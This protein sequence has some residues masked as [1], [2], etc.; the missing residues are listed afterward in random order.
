VEEHNVDVLVIGSGAAG[1]RAS[2]AAREAGAKVLLLSRATAG[3]ATSTLL[4]H[5]AFAAS[6]FGQSIEKHIKKTLET[7]HG[8]NDRQLVKILAEEAPARVWELR[9]KGIKFR[10]TPQGVVAEGTFPVLGRQVIQTLIDWARSTGVRT[11]S[12]IT[13]VALTRNGERVTGCVAVTRDGKPVG[14]RAKAVVLCTGGASA[15]FKFHDN[16][17]F[18]IGDGYALAARSGAAIED[19]EFIQ[20]YP[21]LIIIPR[22]PRI[23]VPPAVVEKGKIVNGAGEDI[24]AKYRLATVRPVA[25]RARDTL[26]IAIYQEMMEGRSVYL[27][28][29][30]AESSDA[31]L[32]LSDREGLRFLENRYQSR[33][34]LIP[35]MPCAHFTIG[36]VVINEDCKTSRDGLFAAGEVACGVHGANRM[37]GNALTETIV[38]GY[39]AGNAAVA[40]LPECGRLRS[41]KREARMLLED[42]AKHQSGAHTPRV[43]LR[44][45]REIMWDNCGPVRDTERLSSA[46]QAVERLKEAGVCCEKASMVPA[47]WSVWNSLETAKMIIGAALSR[48]ES[49]GAHRRAV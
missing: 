46:L 28:I 8:R 5:G 35:V 44:M 12:W 10:E 4:S 31:S 15:L 19:M 49:I 21:L 22:L 30:Q 7:G 20:F 26:S 47:W 9:H 32:E 16:P 42:Q 23:I 43:V 6:G 29:R 48:T 34:R 3:L 13:A 14:V 25:I 40:S 11:I 27:D 33:S 37:G 24:L 1:L 18:N 45:L 39:R 38:F 41:V 17:A 36:G 2:I